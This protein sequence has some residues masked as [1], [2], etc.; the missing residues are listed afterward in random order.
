MPSPDGLRDCKA[1]AHAPDE[2][3]PRTRGA[4]RAAPAPTECT[5]VFRLAN[6]EEVGAKRDREGRRV[7]WS[8]HVGEVSETVKI[9]NIVARAPHFPRAGGELLRNYDEFA[10]SRAAALFAVEYLRTGSLVVAAPL[11]GEEAVRVLDFLGCDVAPS[12][13]QFADDGLRERRYRQYIARIALADDAVQ[14]VAEKFLRSTME[15]MTFVVASNSQE[16]YDPMEGDQ[17]PGI[18]RLWTCADRA[19][20]DMFKAETKS[21]F[22]HLVVVLGTSHGEP[23]PMG[24]RFIRERIVAGLREKQ[25]H[26]EWKPNFAF[27]LRFVGAFGDSSSAEAKR[28]QLHVRLLDEEEEESDGEEEESD[29]EAHENTKTGGGAPA[30]RVTKTA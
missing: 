20:S 29:G 23:E 15:R 7:P 19:S 16:G 27:T 21:L 2:K 5:L 12:A 30:C 4:G 26:G 17:N 13:L 28:W 18:E 24:S 22:N 8:A 11:E 9:A 3:P 6:A 10:F 14:T 25:I 1:D